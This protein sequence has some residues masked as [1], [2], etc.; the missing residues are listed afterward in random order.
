MEKDSD[1]SNFDAWVDS[2]FI[3]EKRKEKE[4]EERAGGKIFK[5]GKHGP[6]VLPGSTG[7]FCSR[8]GP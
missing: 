8:L 1:G 4:A 5:G 2:T 6:G 7:S 3:I